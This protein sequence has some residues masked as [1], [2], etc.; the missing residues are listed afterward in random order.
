MKFPLNSKSPLGFKRELAATFVGTGWSGIVQLA[1][2]PAYIKLMGIE[3]YGLVGFYLVLQAM[4]Q[5]LDLGLSPTINREMARYSV[6]PGK[7]DDARDL[8]RTLEVGYWLIGLLIAAGIIIAS[9]WL[10]VHW[11]GAS[12]IPVRKV[13]LAV[14]LMGMLAFFQ[15]PVSFYQG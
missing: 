9:P 12:A 8:V 11:I 7:A 3:S 2:I 14:M 6:L 1:C 4:L 13:M 15:W 10:S 5:V